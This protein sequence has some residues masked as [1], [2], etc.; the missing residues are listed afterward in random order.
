MHPRVTSIFCS[1]NVS[2]PPEAS[3]FISSC[4]IITFFGSNSFN[5]FAQDGVLPI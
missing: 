5:R 4:A 3:L 1:F 2:M